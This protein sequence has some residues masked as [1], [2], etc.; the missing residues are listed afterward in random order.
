MILVDTNI[1]S[2]LVR[3]RPEPAVRAW[4]KAQAPNL[5][6]ATVVI[7]ELLS[8]AHLL[9]EGRRK[10]AFLAGY[11]AL[12]EAHSHRILGFDLAAAQLYGGIVASQM[13]AGR[14][15][16]TADSQIAAMA[17]ANGLALATRNVK[18]FGGLGLELI[19]PWTA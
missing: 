18:H 9:E 6:L 5:W 11:Q 17:L 4:E 8:G 19:D 12:I 7:G 16:G 13:R 1:W 2:E 14:N 10:Q 15:P 3:P